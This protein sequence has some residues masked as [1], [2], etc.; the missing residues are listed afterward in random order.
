MI[1]LQDRVPSIDGY[2]EVTKETSN[3]KT[4]SE[5][6]VERGYTR[7]NNDTIVI[8]INGIDLEFTRNTKYDYGNPLDNPKY[9]DT[10]TP[11]ISTVL[12]ND[13][14]LTSR[15]GTVTKV[16]SNYVEVE[17]D[18]KTIRLYRKDSLD[19]IR[20]TPIYWADKQVTFES[21]TYDDTGQYYK[22]TFV[23]EQYPD[24]NS[25][26]WLESI[27]DTTFDTDLWSGAGYV[28]KR[29]ILSNQY[30]E[31]IQYKISGEVNGS[32]LCLAGFEIDGIQ[33]TEVPH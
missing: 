10:S 23:G 20:N 29:C 11:S 12:Y 8:K 13:I 21:K 2:K 14:D 6:A 15:Y 25:P 22:L 17:I 28:T 24:D 5:G 18:S 27:T 30:F 9:T 32:S 1:Q 31:T 33:I 16:G 19:S 7:K 4:T 26:V 3:G